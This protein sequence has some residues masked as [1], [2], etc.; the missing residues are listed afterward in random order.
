MSVID[1][2]K[3]NSANILKQPLEK[4]KEKEKELSIDERKALFHIN[5][6][7]IIL[8]SGL[9]FSE[10]L[11]Q[12]ELMKYTTLTQFSNYILEQSKGQEPIQS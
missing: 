12:L 3:F 5:L 6:N 7:K 8:E 2:I 9:S 10:I 11:F 1:N 4:E